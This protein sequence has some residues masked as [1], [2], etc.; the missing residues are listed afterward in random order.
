MKSVASL[1]EIGLCAPDGPHLYPV[2]R[3]HRDTR[4]DVVK[5]EIGLLHHHAILPCESRRYENELLKGEVLPDADVLTAPKLNIRVAG[6]FCRH[7]RKES[8]RVESFRV[9]PNLRVLV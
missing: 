1:F 6:S 3:V 8:I 5:L 9:G 7:L 4:I 2:P